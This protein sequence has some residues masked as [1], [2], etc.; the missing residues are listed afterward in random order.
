[1]SLVSIIG[2]WFVGGKGRVEVIRRRGKRPQGDKRS[3]FAGN[4]VVQ[5]RRCRRGGRGAR[6]SRSCLLSLGLGEGFRI[7]ETSAGQRQ[8]A[9]PDD[10]DCHADELQP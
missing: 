2:S 8:N 6:A 1:M 4:S 5:D 3:C 9:H 7:R 10:D